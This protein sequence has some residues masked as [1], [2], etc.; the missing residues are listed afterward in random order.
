[1]VLAGIILSSLIWQQHVSIRQLEYQ[2]DRRQAEWLHIAATDFARFVLAED[3]RVSGHDHLGEPWAIPLADTKIADFLRG[4]DI[5]QEIRHVSLVGHVSDAQGRF[6]LNSL[7]DVTGQVNSKALSV[8]Q[9]LLENAG[10]DRALAAPIA[11][12]I[13]Q[14]GFRFSEVSQLRGFNGFNDRAIRRLK[15]SL[16][17]LPENTPV[18]VNTAN[19]DILRAIFQGMSS[20][21]ANAFISARL[22]NPLKSNIEVHNLLS[23]LGVSH[24]SDPP[25]IDTKTGYFLTHTEVRFGEALY[26]GESVIRRAPLSPNNPS[27]TKII[28][29]HFF[30]T[31]KE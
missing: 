13:A 21:Q 2:R 30:S 4:V 15:L 17:A 14:S 18:N 6:N 27:L 12:N 7:V 19:A 31:L 1:M 9:H 5:P 16:T 24:S 29:T 10:L 25:L 26:V 23:R 8:F 3:S 20:S 11:N 22:E 28:S